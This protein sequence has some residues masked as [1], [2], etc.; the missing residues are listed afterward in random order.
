M[1]DDKFYFAASVI[2][3]KHGTQQRPITVKW[4][5]VFQVYLVSFAVQWNHRMAS[6]RVAGGHGQ[7]TSCLD[8]RQIQRINQQAEVLFGQEHVL[9]PRRGGAPWCGVRHVPVHQLHCQGLLRAERYR[10]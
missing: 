7:Q 3:C 8:P 2:T 10:S 6:L 4:K 1:V 9:A 5:C